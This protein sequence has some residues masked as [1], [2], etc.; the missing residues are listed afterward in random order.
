MKATRGLFP[1]E[2]ERANLAVDPA[3]VAVGVSA[4]A[5]DAAAALVRR[6]R[7]LVGP[8]ARAALDPPLVPEDLRPRR[9]LDALARR[10]AERTAA[11]REDATRLLDGL[12]PVLTDGFLRR[13]HLT[14]M[15]ARY[16]D[17]DGVVALVDLDAAASRLDVD[18][19]AR[20]LDVEAVLDRIDLTELVLTRVDMEALV[21]AV[22]DRTD[23]TAVVLERVDLDAL[24]GAVLERVDLLGL[25]QYVIDGIDL[26]GII[27]ESTGSMASDTVLGARMQG[28]TA[29]EAVSRVRDRLRFHRDHG[30]SRGTQPGPGSDEPAPSPVVPSPV[31]PSPVVPSAPRQQ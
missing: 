2:T 21:G 31:V 17:V 20:R 24:V 25:A 9:W 1:R 4:L 16:L 18:A 23:L 7:P 26:P 8:L 19:V 13:A 10:G 3:A 28:I 22:L 29:D 27:R 6:T 30:P 5:A 14:T 15:V 11:S 12:I